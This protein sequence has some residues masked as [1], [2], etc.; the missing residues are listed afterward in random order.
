MKSRSLFEKAEL[1]FFVSIGLGCLVTLLRLVM[2]AGL[3]FELGAGGEGTL[4]ATATRV[5]RG[6]NPYPPIT[7]QPPYILNAYGP[8]PC[9]FGALCVKLF[10]LSFTTP[11][12]LV[13]VSAAWCAMLVALLLRRWGVTPPVCVFFGLLFL[14]AGPAQ[15]WVA[16]YRVD[17]IGIAFSLTGLY[18]Y[19]KSRRSY[20]SVPFF[21]IALFCKLTLLAAPFSCFVYALCRR[22]WKKALGFAL[23]GLALGSVAF[24]LIERETQGWFAFDSIWANASTFYSLSGAF[25]ILYK[26]QLNPACVLVVLGLA[27]SYY[28]R[29]RPDLWLPVIYLSSTFLSLFAVGKAGASDNYFLENYAALCLCGGIAYQ[30]FHKQTDYPSPVSALLPATLAAFVMLNLHFPQAPT[31]YS[32]CRPAYDYVKAYPGTIMLSDNVGA[33]LMAGKTSVVNDP[34]MWSDLVAKGGWLET[35]TNVLK[36]IRS[37][38]VDLILLS[39]RVDPTVEPWRQPVLDAIEENYVITKSFNCL[40]VRFVYSPRPP[41]F[42]GTSSKQVLQVWK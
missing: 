19:T 7:Q 24:V 6:L 18:V 32:E 21:I 14:A 28:A 39:S 9:Y 1:L 40:G 12:I 36:L 34:F 2:G 35:G 31:P 16:Y 25:K 33:V 38:K 22:E 41:S 8:V 26:D 4:L 15:E 17:F 29:S 5:A 20:L 11:R 42:S 27:L 23:C 37:R 30:L 13:A 3:P 10:G